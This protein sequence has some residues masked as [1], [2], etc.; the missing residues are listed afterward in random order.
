MKIIWN[1][2]DIWAKGIFARNSRIKSNTN[3]QNSIVRSTVQG[4]LTL[5]PF[6]TKVKLPKKL[7]SEKFMT[8]RYPRRNLLDIILKKL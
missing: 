3:K 1:Y 2:S 7:D 8:F 4:I 6:G 5:N